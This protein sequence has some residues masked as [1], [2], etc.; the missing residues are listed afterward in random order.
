MK[1]KEQNSMFF[2]TSVPL[3]LTKNYFIFVRFTR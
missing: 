2:V 1:K 3:C